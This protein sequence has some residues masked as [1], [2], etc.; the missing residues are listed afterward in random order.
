MDPATKR[1]NE[2]GE[3]IACSKCI[4]GHRTGKCA[5]SP[6][7]QD[8]VQVLRSAGRPA[9]SSTDRARAAAQREKKRK[10][11]V[12]KELKKKDAVGLQRGG[13]DLYLQRAATEPVRGGFGAGYP[14]FPVTEYQN[15]GSFVNHQAPVPS[16]AQRS[17]FPPDPLRVGL[18]EPTFPPWEQ[19]VYPGVGYLPL[20]PTRA[21]PVPVSAPPV[22]D[23]P[24]AA[25]DHAAYAVPLR[26]DGSLDNYG[27]KDQVTGFPQVGMITQDDQG[28]VMMRQAISG[29]LMES[30]GIVPPVTSATCPTIFSS[31]E[32]AEEM[33]SLDEPNTGH[34]D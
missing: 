27:V 18:P 16:V 11:Q 14:T 28:D 6:G 4:K 31:D 20:P 9:G 19:P 34:T 3:R 8:S 32:D 5:D 23:F 29:D 15:L 22:H 2:K 1:T 30:G 13:H 26:I 7:H 12:Q 24:L 21:A 33:D 10:R 17:T 25:P